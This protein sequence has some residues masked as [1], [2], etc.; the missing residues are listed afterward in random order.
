MNLT[1]AEDLAPKL[2][3]TVE[4]LLRMRRRKNWPAVRVANNFFFTDDQIE[5]IIRDLT[6]GGTTSSGQTARSAARGKR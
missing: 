1:P 3:L 4:S 5:H 2:K 6:R